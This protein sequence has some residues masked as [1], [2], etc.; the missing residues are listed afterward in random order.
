MIVPRTGSEVVEELP[1][2]VTCA[3]VEVEIDSWVIALE[4]S[5]VVPLRDAVDLVAGCNEVEL[6]A[7]GKV[8]ETSTLV[9]IGEDGGDDTAG[10]LVATGAVPSDGD[11][12]QMPGAIPEVKPKKPSGD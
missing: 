2:V 5:G 8:V 4:V 1:I 10:K 11:G 7:N 6:V 3:G 12:S 9:G